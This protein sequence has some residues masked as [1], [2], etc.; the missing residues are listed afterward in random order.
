MITYKPIEKDDL[1]ALAAITDETWN[2]RPYGCSEHLC[3]KMAL[4]D[5]SSCY[6][7]S[8]YGLMAVE[9][10]AAVGYILGR[11]E[12]L[13]ARPDALAAR[14][15]CRRLY[16]DMA[17]TKAGEPACDYADL[18]EAVDDALLR[19]TKKTYDG[20]LVFF[21]VSQKA[22][23]KGVG[24]GLYTRFEDWMRGHGAREIYVFTDSTCTFGFYPRH[25]FARRGEM[26]R[27]AALRRGE[28]IDFYI[29]D[30][31]L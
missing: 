13:P 16:F 9:D 3:E 27:T 14:R 26:T 21:A 24:E 18:Y 12:R 11:L 4:A 23:G 28:A 8:N 15:L 1:K 7:R 5:L 31:R 25:G 30:K 19:Q 22:R 17:F 10:G 6:A 29:Y 20:E 2:Y